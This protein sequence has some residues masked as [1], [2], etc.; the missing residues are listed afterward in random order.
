MV[1][2]H[3]LPN[4][5]FAAK[6]LCAWQIF[7]H[8]LSYS[9]TGTISSLPT[10]LVFSLPLPLPSSSTSAFSQKTCSRGLETKCSLFDSS[11]VPAYGLSLRK[12]SF[13]VNVLVGFP[14][15]AISYKCQDAGMGL[16]AAFAVAMALMQPFCPRCSIEASEAK[17]LITV[18]GC[19]V[20]IVTKAQIIREGSLGCWLHL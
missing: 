7:I 14:P 4:L 2:F 10:F 20:T 12:I 5:D 6:C 1:L 19:S 13:Q 3:S 16:K 18:F 17:E 15:L 9:E 8:I 11:F